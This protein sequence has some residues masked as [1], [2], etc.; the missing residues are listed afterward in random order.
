MRDLF[1]LAPPS[2]GFPLRE[3]VSLEEGT[4][5]RFPFR[6][7]VEIGRYEEGMTLRPGMVLIPDPIVSSHHC[8]VHQREDGTCTVRDLSRNGTWLDGRR[9]VPGTE[10]E[11]R[12]GQVL[13]IGDHRFRLDG[14]PSRG[15]PK[16]ATAVPGTVASPTACEVSVLVGDIQGYTVLVREA[17]AGTVQAAVCGVF[18]RL[19]AMVATLG[20]TV[21]EYQGD[22]IFAFWEEGDEDHALA[23][24]RAALRLERHARELGEDRGVWPLSGFPLRMQ[25]ALATGDVVMNAFGGEHRAGLALVGEP[26][27]LAYRLEKLAGEETGSILAPESTWRRASSRFRFREVGQRRLPGFETEHRVFALLGGSGDGESP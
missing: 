7:R 4:E 6:E 20:G 16:A 18:E 24:C 14:E 19:Q 12:T 23:A 21:K 3:L 15:A 11:M 5:R 8:E 25:W 1:F 17:D 9:L 2:S 26:V 22:A 27:V 13:R 10:T